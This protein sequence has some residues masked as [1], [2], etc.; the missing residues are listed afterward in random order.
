[1]LQFQI[2]GIPKLIPWA[3]SA[4]LMQDKR[5]DKI[6]ATRMKKYLIFVK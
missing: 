4:S 3:G 1:L 5:I 6:T 2:G